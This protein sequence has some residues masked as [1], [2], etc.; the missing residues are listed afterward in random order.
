MLQG[1]IN[2]PIEKNHPAWLGDILVV[3]KKQKKHH[4]QELIEVLLNLENAGYRLSENKTEF[5][6]NEIEFVGQKIDPKCV[7]PLQDKLKAI[8]DIK[9]QKTKRN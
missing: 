8:Q 2:Q 3:T 5:S 6:K 9:G 7:R 1:K 4:K